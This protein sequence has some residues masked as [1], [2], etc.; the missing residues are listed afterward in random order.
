MTP[1]NLKIRPQIREITATLDS[2]DSIDTDLKTLY[3]H[4]N[5]QKCTLTVEELQIWSLVKKKWRARQWSPQN[6]WLQVDY[7][8]TD[9]LI[10]W[11]FQNAVCTATSHFDKCHHIRCLRTEFAAKHGKAPLSLT[12]RWWMEPDFGSCQSPDISRSH[13]Y[14]GTTAWTHQPRYIESTL[15]IEDRC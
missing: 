14:R 4:L 7:L 12:T 6:T 13:L 1:N 11:K 2:S 10:I 15:Y 8:C 3:C 9:G 5:F